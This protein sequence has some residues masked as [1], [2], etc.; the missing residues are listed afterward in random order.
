[1]K[2]TESRLAGAFLIEL[3]PERD[4]RGFFARSWSREEFTRRGLDAE[5]SECAI[6]FNLR[7]GTLRG[8]H[9]QVAPFEEAKL[10]RCTAGAIYD[11]IVDMRP[12]SR[13]HRQWA[14][15]EL[16]AENRHLL[17]VPRGFAHGFQTL[18]DATEVFYQLTGPYS[19]EHA[20]AIR[21]DDAGLGISWPATPERIMSVRDRGRSTGERR[22]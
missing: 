3:E 1:M 2:F 12:D 19:P 16:S 20:R 13:T 8:L 6:S 18:V 7:R 17:Y 9:H 22:P 21:W 15:F 4:E 14:A 5:F 11:V 10:V